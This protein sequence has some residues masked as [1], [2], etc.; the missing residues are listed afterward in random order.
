[1][2]VK[3]PTLV[4]DI[5]L[6]PAG[7]KRGAAATVSAFDRVNKASTTTAAGVKGVDAGLYSLSFRAQTVGR[8][9]MRSFGLPILGAVGLAINSF[10]KFENSMVRIEGLVGVSTG[11]VQKFGEAVKEAA[12]ATGRGPQELADAMFFIASAGLR[13]STAID[14]LNASAK[15]SA[16]GLGQTKAVA[17]AAT[18]AVNAY[19]AENLSGSDA[20]DVLTAA[21][22]EGKVEAE[23]LAPAIGKA[24]PV[25]SAM[26]IEFHEV[27][28]AIAAMTRTGT[29]ARTSAIQLR[30]IMQSLLDPSRQTEK[31]LREMGI[32]QGE[33]ADQAR[34]KGLLFVLKRL[35]DLASENE[36]AFA[37]VFPNIRALAGALD[38]TGENLAENEQIF[39][40][41][42]SSTGDTDRAFRVIQDTVQFKFNTAMA[43]LKNAIIEAGAAF[44]PLID[45]VAG[46][47]RAFA[48]LVDAVSGNKMGPLIVGI[49]AATVAFGGLLVIA[50]SAA[51]AMLFFAQAAGTAATAST[52]AAG[53]A[54]SAGIAKM[55][56]GLTKLGVVGLAAGVA[57]GVTALA[58]SLMGR[59]SETTAEKVAKVRA[60]LADVKAVADISI[61]SLTTYT[62]SIRGIE[63]A[64]NGLT[65]SQA[66]FETAFG[67]SIREVFEK[68]GTSTDAGLT[69]AEALIRTFGGQENT[70][71]LR[72]AFREIFQFI[73]V[74]FGD[75]FDNDLIESVF[76]T[77]KSNEIYEAILGLD[78]DESSRQAFK[79]N[80]RSQ[81]LGFV[82]EVV[83]IQAEAQTKLEGALESNTNFEVVNVDGRNVVTLMEGAFEALGE[84]LGEVEKRVDEVVGKDIKDL[85]KA[86]NGIAKLFVE[87]LES[88][89]FRVAAD[90]Y[91][92][93][94]NT[95]ANSV[96][97]SGGDVQIAIDTVNHA[98]QTAA[99]E[100]D[101]IAQDMHNGLS[102]AVGP[103][104]SF[105]DIQDRVRK[106]QD[107]MAKPGNEGLS[108]AD[109]LLDQNLDPTKI[110][111]LE[112]ILRFAGFVEQASK[113]VNRIISEQDNVSE[114]HVRIGS[115]EIPKDAEI[116]NRATD[117]LEDFMRVQ[118]TIQDGGPRLR[119]V[120]EVFEALEVAVN[121]AGKRAK[122]FKDR[123]DAL[124][125]TLFD[126]KNEQLG[127]LDAFQSFADAVATSG[128]SLDV[129]TAKGRDAQKALLGVIESS[130]D[131]A[132]AGVASQQLTEGQAAQ[133]IQEQID[134]LVKTAEMNGA[135]Q[136]EVLAII[137]QLGL[138]TEG[139]IVRA[140][141]LVAAPG[142]TQTE[143]TAFN[144][145]LT[146]LVDNA[147]GFLDFNSMKVVGFNVIGGIQQG[148]LERAENLA[149]TVQ[150]IVNQIEGLFVGE[151]KISS[152]S[153]RFAEEVGKPI[154]A[155]IAK[156]MLDE[157]GK[158]RFTIKELVND[159]ISTAQ[160]QISSVFE[161]IRSN[162]NLEKARQELAKVMRDF[163]S[164]GEITKR[165][166]LTRKQLE[167]DLKEAERAMRLGTGHQED[168]E[169][170]L[171]D[172]REALEE[173]DANVTS[174]APITEAQVNL[175]Q[176]GFDM[177]NAVAVMKMEGDKA[178]ELFQNLGETMGLPM[179]Q[180]TSALGVAT[181]NID[182]YRNMFDDDV[183][184]A[185]ERAADAFIIIEESTSGGSITGIVAPGA[186]T[187]SG[188]ELDFMT[189]MSIFGQ[190]PGSQALTA[191]ASAPLGVLHDPAV[192][193]LLNPSLA[194]GQMIGGFTGANFRTGGTPTEETFT[195]IN[196]SLRSAAGN[197]QADLQ[198]M[199]LQ[200]LREMKEVSLMKSTTSGRRQLAATQYLG[201]SHSSTADSY[202]FG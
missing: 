38:I 8:R 166:S 75:A 122:E 23:R 161:A 4:Q 62:N 198:E 168:L 60:E 177:A 73:K 146:A 7:L 35:R 79:L 141:G 116:I 74:E 68:G 181:S 45:A 117:A 13:G 18:S 42:A 182:T 17:D 92:E 118:Q 170:S 188:T 164:E 93:L 36:E 144:H 173:F 194:L 51:Q 28:A 29:D 176:A 59:R 115:I 101:G 6:N 33:L 179:D 88:G 110:R 82:D 77:V 56:L 80:V 133:F 58:F 136:E 143:S 152:P 40:A 54:G 52:A 128:G 189:L 139:D 131:F 64:M 63:G 175:M 70:P 113:D 120:E 104:E 140:L 183:L 147:I 130:V 55:T 151:A 72:K 66:G 90:L 174:G 171:L 27:A 187:G 138:G 41:L 127:T 119:T 48:G 37:D 109:A 149:F 108:L 89:D 57:I 15:A 71:E 2:A 195:N 165:E 202:L 43:D 5:V 87:S 112:D 123:F 156:G 85:S 76:G 197:S 20:V 31:A 196:D 107:E 14:V 106:A 184:R 178:I 100:A 102:R 172:A 86:F 69:A 126:F 67:E 32:A 25:A 193:A 105:L 142:T 180:I 30:Q 83:A 191:E 190:T 132:A 12:S 19:G 114:G 24:I 98:F 22:R 26:G 44:A 21:V 169:L 163:G 103:V 46:T 200:E 91:D 157:R 135:T 201:I 129:F 61:K 158:I 150:Q 167:R 49:A 39:A 134:F 185:I 94:I 3:L 78:S 84:D 96:E 154:T 53:A 16:I 159:T 125:S 199:T 148:M 81:A 47:L 153:I 97:A 137:A 9:F 186:G 121:Q 1:M 50:G 95:I 111:N 11:Q 124:T 192:E 162:I 65:A 155:G 160:F 34:E 145:Q 10:G 99:S